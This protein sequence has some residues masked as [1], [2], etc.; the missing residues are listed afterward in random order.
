MASQ[1]NRWRAQHSQTGL[2]VRVPG[3]VSRRPKS[4]L[5]V[6]LGEDLLSQRFWWEGN[7]LARYTRGHGSE[8]RDWSPEEPQ[9]LVM[10]RYT[11]NKECE[12][13]RR[14]SLW[15]DPVPEQCPA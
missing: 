2:E 1:R 8:G 6:Q 5:G 11:R 10:T 15:E 9:F 4:L 3:T 12:A 14:S 13:P 7:H